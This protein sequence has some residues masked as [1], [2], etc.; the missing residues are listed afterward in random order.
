MEVRGAILNTRFKRMAFF[1]NFAVAGLF[2]FTSF[3]SFGQVQATLDTTSIRIG[4][5]LTYTMIVEADTTD[6]VVFP[7]GQQ[8]LP[9]EV[10]E[11]YKLDTI[12]NNSRYR[13][14]KKYGLTQFDSGRYQIPAQRVIIN[15][16]QFK[17]DTMTVEVRDVLVDTTKQK[18][19]TIKD[20]ID[21]DSPPFDFLKLLLWLLPILALIG[22]VAYIFFRRK[23]LREAQEEDLPPYEEA[24]D[25]LHK[26]D[27]SQLLIQNKSKE[28]YSILTEI[29]KRYLDR[30]VDDMALEST[31]DELIERL[32]AHKKLG[33]FDF[34]ATMIKDLE[35][36]L[37]RADLVKFAKMQQASGQ[38]EADRRTLELIINDTHEAIPEPTEEELLEDELYKEEQYKK[39][40]RKNWM[41]AIGSILIAGLFA[42]AIGIGVYGYS[43]VRDFVF[44][45]DMRELQEDR[46][47]KSE[48][49]IP[50]VIMETPEVLIRVPM[51]YEENEQ[52]A[53]KSTDAFAYG[54]LTDDLYIMVNTIQYNS[55]QK[56]DPDATIEAGLN[57]IELG[58]A[59]NF[60]VKK[61]AFETPNGIAGVRAIGTFNIK[62]GSG[63][64]EQEY[65]YVVFGQPGALQQVVIVNNKQNL[66]AK[67]IVER[68]INSLEIELTQGEK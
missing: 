12:L 21:V 27:D 13:F 19:F 66:Y 48:Y 17:T 34:D 60:I 14:I 25:A 40:I 50:S 4:E 2:L 43:A 9:M 11:S 67:Q 35:L 18:M 41:I 47:V 32:S 61:D 31:T 20:K 23:K 49:G 1:Q 5:E 22:A 30:E 65:Q 63:F 28:Y 3:S 45:N 33:H 64:R 51:E 68:I 58:G 52:A 62:K 46:W 29:V 56:I 42:I 24:I 59:S 44:G 7:E 54:S 16:K 37:K 15:N 38:L 26:L 57:K 39:R 8:F 10:I 36:V 55:E 53:I 6:L